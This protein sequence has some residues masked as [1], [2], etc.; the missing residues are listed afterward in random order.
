MSRAARP[1]ARRALVGVQNLKWLSLFTDDGVLRLWVRGNDL[2]E[3][4]EGTKRRRSFKD[5][6]RAASSH[7]VDFFASD[8]P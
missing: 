2:A 6:Y 7:P 3:V 1:Q 4:W 5:R 8:S